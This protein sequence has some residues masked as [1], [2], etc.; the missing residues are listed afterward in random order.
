MQLL[1]V[2]HL[3][4]WPRFHQEVDQVLSTS[5]P[6]VIEYSQPLSSNMISVQSAILVALN[7]VLKELKKKCN[8]LIDTSCLSLDNGV[9]YHFSESIRSQLEP[10]WHKLTYSTKQYVNDLKTLRQLLDSLIRYDA[11][12]FYDYLL[13]LQ[14]SSS[15]TTSQSSPSCWLTSSIAHDLFQCSKERVVRTIALPQ[16]SKGICIV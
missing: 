9:F 12:S 4:L 5:Q 1:F 7:S 6:D 10:E 15:T 16:Q 14:E 11:I 3:H 2:K 13:T 8:S